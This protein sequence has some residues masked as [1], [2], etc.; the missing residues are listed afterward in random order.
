MITRSVI[1]FLLFLN[2]CQPILFAVVINIQRLIACPE[3]MSQK[4]NLRGNTRKPCSMLIVGVENACHRRAS[5]FIAWK[6]F[7]DDLV[8]QSGS[9]A[10]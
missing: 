4:L 2:L 3:P 1:E 5:V 7:K 9:M 10:Q 6:L 8:S